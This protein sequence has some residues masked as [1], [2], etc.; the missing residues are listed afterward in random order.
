MS[1]K[2]LPL[3]Q[4]GPSSKETCKT[5]GSVQHK[6]SDAQDSGQYNIQIKEKY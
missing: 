5:L 1:R 4:I 3:N 6:Y 2:V